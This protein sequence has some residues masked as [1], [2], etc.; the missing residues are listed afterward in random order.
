MDILFVKTAKEL[1]ESG[2]SFAAIEVC[3]KGIK[4]YPNYPLA[5]VMLVEAYFL[6]GHLEEAAKELQN[7][8]YLFPFYRPLKKFRNVIEQTELISSI[9]NEL[10]NP[11]FETDGLLNNLSA[12]SHKNINE[13]ETYTNTENVASEKDENDSR[14]FL[15]LVRFNSV[16]ESNSEDENR[17]RA[18]NRNIIAGM[19]I[20]PLRPSKK[21][22]NAPY[23]LNEPIFPEFYNPY[24]INDSDNANTELF[25]NNN[26]LEESFATD[27][28]ASILES[29]GAY[30]QAIKVYH[31]LIEK[32]P[33][34]ENFYNSKIMEI[35]AKIK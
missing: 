3:Q 21:T 5:R 23:E 34:K 24:A 2:D 4:K 22:S 14:S 9:G 26:T 27:T 7:S 33:E 11:D 35:Q 12:N 19:N 18:S 30:E 29:Q 1:L 17:I 28:L 25:A 13:Q 31:K 20:S 32:F 15:K 16:N 10:Y 8:Y 6:S